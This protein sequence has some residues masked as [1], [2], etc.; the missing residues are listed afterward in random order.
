MTGNKV[1]TNLEA[2]I[3]DF[4][5]KTLELLISEDALNALK[6]ARVDKYGYISCSISRYDLEQ[7]VGELSLDANHSKNQYKAEMANIAAEILE[8]YL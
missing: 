5:V 8:T 7:M 4:I 6:K 3:R 1:K 2:P